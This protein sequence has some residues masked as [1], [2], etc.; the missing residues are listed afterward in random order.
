MHIGNYIE[1]NEDNYFHYKCIEALKVALLA[2]SGSPPIQML[3]ALQECY[4]VIEMIDPVLWIVV[5]QILLEAIGWLTLSNKPL[6]HRN[7]L[8]WRY[9]VISIGSEYLAADSPTFNSLPTSM[10]TIWTPVEAI[11]PLSDFESHPSGDMKTQSRG[12][13]PPT[14]PESIEHPFA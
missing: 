2:L 10:Q 9:T 13:Q 11:N 14:F 3:L 7:Y 12:S 1:F 8:F 4:P 6:Y 5:S